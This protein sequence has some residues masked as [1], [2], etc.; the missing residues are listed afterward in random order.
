MSHRRFLFDVCPVSCR[1][2]G[3]ITAFQSY[4]TFLEAMIGFGQK[5]GKERKRHKVFI[6]KIVLQFRRNFIPFLIL[7]IIFPKER[8]DLFIAWN[9][10]QENLNCKLKQDELQGPPFTRKKNRRKCDMFWMYILILISVTKT[11]TQLHSF[12]WQFVNCGNENT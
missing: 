4:L 2:D 6:A 3:P 10:I 7:V 11:F 1:V 5:K 12:I 9:L 8:N